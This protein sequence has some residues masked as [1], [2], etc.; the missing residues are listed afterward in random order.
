MSEHLTIPVPPD[1]LERLKAASRRLGKKP[2]ELA[3]ELV[4]RGL[5]PPVTP[6]DFMHWAGAFCSDV[7]DAA[8]RHDDYLGQ[9]LHRELIARPE[10]PDVR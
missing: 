9:A 3:A 1:L 8:E 10:P 7:P 2:E 5:G 6:D 4:D